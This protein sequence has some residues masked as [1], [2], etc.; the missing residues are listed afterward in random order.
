MSG[1]GKLG[2]HMG[3]PLFAESNRDVTVSSHCRQLANG[4]VSQ[5]RPIPEESPIDNLSVMWKVTDSAGS[6]FEMSAF[7]RFRGE[8]CSA[9]WK[10]V[11]A[12]LKTSVVIALL[13]GCLPFVIAS[14]KLCRSRSGVFQFALVELT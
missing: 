7:G 9:N 11:V 2:C 5:P 3:S 12:I 4:D 1:L 10:G 6:S 8:A 13:T 14:L